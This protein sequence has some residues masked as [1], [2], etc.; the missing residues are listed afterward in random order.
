MREVQIKR[1][2]DEETVKLE[3]VMTFVNFLELQVTRNIS[4]IEQ[5]W[6]IMFCNMENTYLSVYGMSQKNVGKNLEEL[7]LLADVGGELNKW[8]FAVDWMLLGSRV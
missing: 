3:Q 4:V 5:F 8:G 2:Y 7:G 6:F 1:K